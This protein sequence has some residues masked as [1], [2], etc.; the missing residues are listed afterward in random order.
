MGNQKKVQ[1]WRKKGQKLDKVGN[2]IKQEI[3]KKRKSKKVGNQKNR[4]S[5]K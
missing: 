2:W 1:N 4:K 3:G 5:K